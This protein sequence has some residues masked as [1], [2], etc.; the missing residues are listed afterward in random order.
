MAS[1]LKRSL[2]HPIPYLFSDR[3]GLFTAK[4][5]SKRLIEELYGKVTDKFLE[6]LLGVWTWPFAY[7]K[8]IGRI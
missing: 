3:A 4:L 2:L 1:R 6:L 5:W 7:P 8:A